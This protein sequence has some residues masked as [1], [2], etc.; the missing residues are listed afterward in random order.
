[1]IIIKI[2]KRCFFLAADYLES[3]FSEKLAYQISETKKSVN[4][5]GLVLSS[6]MFYLYRPLDHGFMGFIVT[7][8]WPSIR[9][10]STVWSLRHLPLRL[11]P[12]PQW[13]LVVSQ[14]GYRDGNWGE[15]RLGSAPHPRP[16]PK[17]LNV[18]IFLPTRVPARDPIP[19]EPMEINCEY[20]YYNINI[21]IKFV[22]RASGNWVKEIRVRVS[23]WGFWI[24]TLEANFSFI[25]T[26]FGSGHCRDP[27]H[28]KKITILRMA[29]I[30]PKHIMYKANC[31]VYIIEFRIR[32]MLSNAAR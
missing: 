29:C 28:G 25:P 2:V 7:L 19:A 27:L 18:E 10:V 31:I 4:K 23:G 6:I 13:C 20:K 3:G 14:G 11:D 12:S 26:A 32:D 5:I 22:T 15:A 21:Q 8:S 9:R 16:G 24:S 30:R 1:M 17:M